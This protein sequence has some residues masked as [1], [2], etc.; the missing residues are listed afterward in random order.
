M[1]GA[2][3]CIGWAVLLFIT[4][5]VDWSTPSFRLTSRDP[6]RP[7]LIAVL[8][9]LGYWYIASDVVAAWSK[10]LQAGA[11]TARVVSAGVALAVVFVGLAWG[12]TA[13]SGSDPYGYV[14]QA[15][16]WK[17]GQ[18]TIDQSAFAPWP[19]EDWTLAPL[20]YRPGLDPHTIV[21]TYPPGLP[22]LMAAADTV[23]GSR[24]RSLV[25]PLLGGLTVWLTFMLGTLVVDEL[26]GL[27][28]CV[29]MAVSPAFLYQLMWPMSDVPATAA[30]TLA[31]VLALG[32][33]RLAAG[34]ASGLAIA[35]R[36]NLLFLAIAVGL[37]A[38][39]PRVSE[40]QTAW[41]VV[42]RAFFFGLGV[43]PAIAGLAGLNA[44]LYGT[45]WNSG[46][47][48]VAG[49][50]DRHNVWPNAVLYARWLL[51]TQ[52]PF[53]LL[54]IPALVTG[55]FA[56][57]GTLAERPV[58]RA[59]LGIFVVTVVMSYLPYTRFDEW[60]YVRFML[61]AVPVI[62]VAAV[63][64][65]R[66]MKAVWGSATSVASLTA[67]AILVFAWEITTAQS[68]GA[69]TVGSNGEH[70]AIVG[71]EVETMTPESSVVF[72]MFH[73]GSARYYA[74]RM[75]IRYD[76]LPEDA[77]DDALDVLA[78]RR[79]R[80]Y[81]LLEGW[82]IDRVRQRFGQRSAVGRLDWQPA[83]QWDFTSGM[84]RLYEA[85][86]RAAAPLSPPGR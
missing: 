45:P 68:H 46:Y 24:G 43:L 61:P 73:S 47:G 55:R 65:V 10:R 17:T 60:T 63:G 18:L 83:R 6:F 4:G 39:Q 69:F 66:G 51:E 7:V 38:L 25:V 79:L 2:S 84:V 67:V 78:A 59:G 26:V 40:R 32:R 9:M 33:R 13:V 86:P 57:P 14:S 11:R 34:V 80:A 28:A 22:L 49:I 21:P 70:S 75:T 85:I 15:D 36:P 58:I 41:E 81:F 71:R 50:F 30:W 76:L 29:L 54:A 64:F 12:T 27:F 19:Y 20:G 5:G 35:I 52:S 62:L 23:A 1:I 82:E 8:L 44:S 77:L 42:R 72:S 16:L 48:A 56:I 37:I 74:R 53:V 31:L 3:L